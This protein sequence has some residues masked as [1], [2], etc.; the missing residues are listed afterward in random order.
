MRTI[1]F[2]AWVVPQDIEG[3]MKGGEPYMATQGDGDIET[4]QSFMFHYSEEKNLMQYVGLKDKNGKEIFEGDIITY[5]GWGIPTKSKIVFN[6]AIASFQ[7]SYP[8]MD[9]HWVTDTLYNHESKKYE[10]IGNIYENPELL[11]K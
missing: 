10:V 3:V 1:K 7:H 4:L 11:S 5:M 2:R 8:N 9:S 6:E